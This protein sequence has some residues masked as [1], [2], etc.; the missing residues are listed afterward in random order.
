MLK[1][2]ITL[3]E[4]TWLCVAG[5]VLTPLVGMVWALWGPRSSRYTG[6]GVAFVG[7]ANLAL[8]LV[9]NGITNR[10]GLDTVANLLVNLAFF[11]GLG[12]GLGAL[13]AFLA[14][15]RAREAASAR[16]PMD[17]SHQKE[18]S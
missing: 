13:Y 6:V 17:L 9:Y 1:E 10:L 8:W 18:G 12:V 16:T 5:A 15:R 14:R 7:P 4:F 3:R 11:V 2:L